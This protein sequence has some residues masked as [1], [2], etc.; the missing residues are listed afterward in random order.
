MVTLFRKIFIKN[1]NDVQNQKVRAAHG[2]LGAWFGIFTNFLL[3]LMK[4]T[5]AVLLARQN[6]WVFSAAIIGDTINNFSD[7]ASSI[8]TLVGFRIS[9]KP[10]DKEH[11]FGHQ[12][13]EYI[14]G[15]FVAVLVV[16][17]AGELLIQSVEKIIAGEEITFDVLTIV[18]LGVSI[19][20]KAMQGLFYRGLAKAIDSSTLKSAA[21]DSFGDCL[22]TGVILISAALSLIFSWGFLDPYLGLAVSLFTIYSGIRMIIETSSP[23]IGEAADI[24]F[25]DKIVKDVLAHEKIE[26]VHD[27]ICHSYGPNSYFV[28]LHAE[29]NQDVSFVDAHEIADELED[30]MKKKYGIVI[31]VHMDPIAVGDPVT[32]A[33]HKEVADTLKELDPKISIHD[34]RLVPGVETE[35]MIFDVLLPY[36]DKK[37]AKPVC[38]EA[39]YECLNKHFANRD[40]KYVFQLKFDRPFAE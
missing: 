25:V 37:D 29:I 20:M 22:S 23:L 34:F 30:E 14:A 19:A 4:L 31:T 8:I 36:E 38:E 10:A 16:V 9:E 3:A 33:F 32:D 15:L 24:T 1:Y 26:G 11:P 28:S 21:L 39:V 5:L 18:I 40:K 13:I 17:A 7:M 35:K 2:K 6:N 12:R 27:V